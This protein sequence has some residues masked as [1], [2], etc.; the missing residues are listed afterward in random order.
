MLA[1]FTLFD[2]ASV[3]YSKNPFSI[4]YKYIYIYLYIYIY[5]YIYNELI[6]G[7]RFQF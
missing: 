7:T 1:R 3:N 5:I 2:L 4:N 6:S